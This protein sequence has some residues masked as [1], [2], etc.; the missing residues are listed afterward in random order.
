MYGLNGS[1][2][3]KKYLKLRAEAVLLKSTQPKKRK[4]FKAETEHPKLFEM[5]RNLRGV[6]SNSEDI[7]HFQ[8]FTQHTLYEMCDLLP[9]N[10]KQLKSH[11]RNGK[12]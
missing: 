12:N 3:I 7:P 4:E 10:K 1:F 6:I 11:S 9:L 8:V 5:L 2:T